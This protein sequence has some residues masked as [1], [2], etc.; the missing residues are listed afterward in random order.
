MKDF[1]QKLKKKEKT[2]LKNTNKIAELWRK[3][4]S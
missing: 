3:K 2:K 1:K 4:Q